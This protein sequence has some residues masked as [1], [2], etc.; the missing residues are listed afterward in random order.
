MASGIC[1]M[2]VDVY[3]TG[4]V[5]TPAVAFMTQAMQADAGVVISASH[6]PM[7]DN[8]IKFFGADG[9]KLPDEIEDEIEAQ[10]KDF[11]RDRGRWGVRAACAETPRCLGRVGATVGHRT[12][13]APMDRNSSIGASHA[14]PFFFAPNGGTQGARQ[15]KIN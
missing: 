2:G 7:R 3:L 6:N 15:P 11:A 9:Y 1:S 12:M 10:M 14:G 5:P 4:V 13:P 8:G